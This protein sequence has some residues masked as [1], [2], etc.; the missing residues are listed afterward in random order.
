MVLTFFSG[1]KKIFAPFLIF[2]IEI[3]TEFNQFYFITTTKCAPR[4][5]KKSYSTLTPD[6]FGV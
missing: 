1:S 6:D 3:H 2:E 4:D 5:K